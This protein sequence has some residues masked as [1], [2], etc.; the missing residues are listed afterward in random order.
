MDSSFVGGLGTSSEDAEI[1]RAT[2]AMAHALGLDVVAE[3]VETAL[4]ADRL[5]ELD[6]DRGQGW[7]FGR[8]VPPEELPFTAPVS[9]AARAVA[10][11][12]HR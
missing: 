11:V 5:A 9:A 3:G 10:Q 6:V 2:V 1:I 12:D 8:P 7:L 4:Q